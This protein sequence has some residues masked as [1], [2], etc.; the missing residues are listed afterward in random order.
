VG[1]TYWEVRVTVPKKDDPWVNQSSR[2]RA[3]YKK[4]LPKG[5]KVACWICGQDEPSADQLDHK[6]P[7]SKFPDLIWDE[8]NIVPAHGDCNNKKSDNLTT[9]G[10]G[11]P[12]EAW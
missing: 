6:L 3:L 2:R 5:K 12:S 9:P 11:F 10:I 4:F 1:Y 8:S 7:R